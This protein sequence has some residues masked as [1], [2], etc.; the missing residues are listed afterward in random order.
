MQNK[1]HISFACVS[2]P[3]KDTELKNRQL[4]LHRYLMLFSR[5]RENLARVEGAIAKRF[6]IALTKLPS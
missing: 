3:V 1:L 6:A 4:I 2:Y 5:R